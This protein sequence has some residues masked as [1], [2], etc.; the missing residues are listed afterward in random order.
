MARCIDGEANGESAL[1]ELLAPKRLEFYAN[2]WSFLDTS[3]DLSDVITEITAVPREYIDGS[4]PLAAASIAR[5]MSWAAERR[6]TRKEDT[7]CE[8]AER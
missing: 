7:A 4:A 3:P 2:D 8:S 1:Q 5:R 6:T